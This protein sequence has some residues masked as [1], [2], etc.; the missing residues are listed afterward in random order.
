MRWTASDLIADRPFRLRGAIG[1]AT[2]TSD[3]PCPAGLLARP[4]HLQQPRDL[5][6]GQDRGYGALQF[7]TGGELDPARPRRRRQRPHR[8][9]GLLQP[10]LERPR[11]GLGQGIG[12]DHLDALGPGPLDAIED[13]RLVAGEL[14]TGPERVLADADRDQ[15]VRRAPLTA[16]ST[17]VS[18]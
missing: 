5:V 17:Q 12:T 7:P 15:L 9:L 11:L 2:A 10:P 14:V 4:G 8:R 16:S 18:N 3:V 6:L 1:T 13:G